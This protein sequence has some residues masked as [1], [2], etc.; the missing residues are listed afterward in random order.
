V[1]KVAKGVGSS[2]E[3]VEYND[4]DGAERT[5][6]GSSLLPVTSSAAIEDAFI[7]VGKTEYEQCMWMRFKIGSRRRRQLGAQT[8]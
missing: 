8:C 5:D 3:F 1:F 4:C 2:D 6:H 7:V